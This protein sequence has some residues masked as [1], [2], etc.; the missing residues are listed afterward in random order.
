MNGYRTTTLSALA[1]ARM[2]T[3]LHSGLH[4]GHAR[5]PVD[6]SFGRWTAP[7]PAP[8]DEPPVHRGVAPLGEV[9]RAPAA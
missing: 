7:A 1:S 6:G 4:S 8:R 3:R 2:S 9:A 5:A